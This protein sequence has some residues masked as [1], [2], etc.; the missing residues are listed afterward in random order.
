[1]HDGLWLWLLPAAPLVGSALCAVLHFAVLAA[2]RRNA[3]GGE[4]TARVAASVAV[5]AMAA[6]FGLSILGF[7]A[8]ANL[9]AEE[10]TLASP[11]WHWIQTGA[12]PIDLALVLDPLSSVMTLV[13]TGVG[14]LIHVYATGYMKGDRGYA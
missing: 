13:I 11:A 14:L 2:R 12:F 5:L 10:R 6:A 8:L 4:R 1:M 3:G 7:K 9:P